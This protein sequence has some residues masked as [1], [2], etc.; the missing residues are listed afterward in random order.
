[1]FCTRYYRRPVELYLG[2]RPRIGKKQLNRNFIKRRFEKIRINR[3]HFVYSH[4]FIKKQNVFIRT[5]IVFIYFFEV[6]MFGLMYYASIMFLS[7]K[8]FSNKKYKTSLFIT[9]HLMRFLTIKE[10]F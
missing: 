6:L 8:C 4:L 9:Y 7:K 3:Y 2:L 5:L 10:Y 1:M